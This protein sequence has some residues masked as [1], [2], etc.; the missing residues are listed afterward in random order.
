MTRTATGADVVT[1][2]TP[3]IRQVTITTTLLAAL[4]QAWAAI[5]ARH[6]E[7]PEV[8]I[9]TGTLSER[10]PGRG[11]LAAARWERGDG[12]QVPE[13]L[14]AGDALVNGPSALAALLHHAAHGLASARGVRDTSRQGRYHS[15]AY[16]ELAREVGLDV[17]Q[18]SAAGWSQ[19]RLATTTADEYTEVLG[20]LGAALVA[21]R[22]SEPRSSS[23]GRT[24]NNNY[25]VA[26]CG[27][28]SPRRIRVAPSV[29]ELGPIT[30]GLCGKAFTPGTD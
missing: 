6:P 23:T 29:L 26:V 28:P 18:T 4:D 15:K 1:P 25:A 17:E 27:C 13:L 11:A 24:S 22:V 20:G 14:L 2:A 21:T 9:T 3:T 30:C 8:A 7:V 10:G 5:R 19:T 16:A 12:D